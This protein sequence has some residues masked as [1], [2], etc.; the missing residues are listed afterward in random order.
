MTNNRP[1]ILRA[2]LAGMALLLSAVLLGAGP[3]AA[4]DTYSSGSLSTLSTR[5]IDYQPTFTY[6]DLSTARIARV[7]ITPIPIP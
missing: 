7:G 4:A 1:S 6:L 2:G 3:A 5:T